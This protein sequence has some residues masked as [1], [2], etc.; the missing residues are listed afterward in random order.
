MKIK[1]IFSPIYW[2]TLSVLLFIS[3]CIKSFFIYKTNKAEYQDTTRST[4]FSELSPTFFSDIFVRIIS[5]FLLLLSLTTKKRRIRII[6]ITIIFL[7]VLLFAIDL[8]TLSYAWLRLSLPDLY[9]MIT[10]GAS[11]SGNIAFTLIGECLG[12]I[13]I[14]LLIALIIQNI[15]KNTLLFSNVI[16][17]L[18]TTT[19]FFTLGI[20]NDFQK[21]DLS[22]IFTVNIASFFYKND[23]LPQEEWPK[24]YLDYF[25][26]EEGEW[27]RPNIIFLFWESLSAI[28]SKKAWGNDNLPAFDKIADKGIFLSH[29]IENG[30]TSDTAH[31]SA[32]LGVEPL[33]R[34]TTN[35]IYSGYKTPTTPLAQ[36]FNELG[37]S[38]TFISTA[39]LTFLNQRDLIKEVGFENI[40]WEEA[41]TDKEKYSFEAASDKELYNKIIEKTEEN[42]QIEKPFLIAGQTISFHEDYESPY[43]N[44]PEKALKYADDSLDSFYKQL[45]EIWF[46]E[47]G[48][49]IIIGD[50]RKRLPIEEGEKER[51]WYPAFYNT[52]GL[53]V[54][55]WISPE[56]NTNYV[57]PSDL[58]Y[59]LKQY[60]ATGDFVTKKIYNS[61]FWDKIGRDRTL[62]TIYY[63][64]DEKYIIFDFSNPQEIKK[65]VNFS[66]LKKSRPDIYNYLA[67]YQNY[68]LNDGEESNNI[69]TLISHRWGWNSA[70]SS[71]LEGF[72]NAK[73]QNLQGVEF[74]IS[75]T[76]DRENVVLHG[77][78]LYETTCKKGKIHNRTLSEIKD[79][80]PLYN[81]EKVK[82]LWELLPLINGLF[83][84]YFL[85]IKAYDYE[86][87]DEVKEQTEEAIQTVKENNMEDKIIFISYHD[88]ARE[89]LL[90]ATGIIIGRD[91]WD[92]EDFTDE[93]L[94]SNPTIQYF[95]TEYSAL[96]QETINTVHNAWKKV[97]AYTVNST[98]DLQKMIDLG[99]DMV[100]TDEIVQLPKYL[101]ELSLPEISS[102]E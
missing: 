51:I 52:I 101:E 48:I 47:N 62:S 95:L 72:F 42:L 36:Y 87:E 66:D 84:D 98:W 49:L 94:L 78:D 91:T 14:G 75:I 88:I 77:E 2:T 54:G 70:N 61:V 99:V 82:K 27:K 56:I 8:L 31:I 45:E 44:T 73:K 35:N 10:S 25:Q 71:T 11:G 80:C 55:T 33:F 15:Q 69:I 65:Y 43:G 26:I 34:G 60:T 102:E 89:T 32:L 29:V 28:D 85:E 53:I 3:I 39:K 41:F 86:P 40:I 90:N 4:I 67:S 21:T 9:V 16:T 37:Y 97:V 6:C 22:N 100:M 96:T 79:K 64:E 50:H 74:D 68:Q 30:G 23:I 7:F 57:Q 46:F 92:I 58:F 18:L 19:F 76:K 17:L 63:H 59:S 93:N 38:T 20:T 13:I 83:N 12:Y 81:Q 5:L 24:N 1:R